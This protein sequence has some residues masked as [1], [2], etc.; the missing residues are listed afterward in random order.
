MPTHICHLLHRRVNH[1]LFSRSSTSS[2]TQS[3][4]HSFNDTE[5]RALT[6]V[7]SSEGVVR[8]GALA[9]SGVGV[10]A[11]EALVA[12]RTSRSVEVET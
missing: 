11:G 10:D 12:R 9:T 5:E 1:S 3:V 8:L 6:W 4:V 2:S 7:D